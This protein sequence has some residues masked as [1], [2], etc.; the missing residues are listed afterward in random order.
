LVEYKENI[1]KVKV[2]KGSKEFNTTAVFVSNEQD[3]VVLKSEEKICNFG[4]EICEKMCS[5]NIYLCGHF[6]NEIDQLKICKKDGWLKS[7]KTERIKSLIF[8]NLNLISQNT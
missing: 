8:L 6:T 2:C 5:G 3:F 4:P 7:S 1:T